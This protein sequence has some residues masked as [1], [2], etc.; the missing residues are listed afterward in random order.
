VIAAAIARVAR[1][2]SW[3]RG[4]IFWVGAG[5][6][7]GRGDTNHPHRSGGGPRGRGGGGGRATKPADFIFFI[8][9]IP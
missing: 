2:V 5:F 8:W 6:G 7:S 1:C 9:L 4:S 3:M